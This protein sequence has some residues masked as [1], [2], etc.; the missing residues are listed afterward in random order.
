MILKSQQI[1]GC[2]LRMPL[3]YK[4]LLLPSFPVVNFSLTKIVSPFVFWCD[5][6]LG[7]V[8]SLD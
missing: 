6:K 1:Y 5:N 8:G 4:A 2:D 3:H 7:D